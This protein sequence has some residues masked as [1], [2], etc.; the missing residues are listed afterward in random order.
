[1]IRDTKTV[2]VTPYTYDPAVDPGVDCSNDPGHTRQEFQEECDINNIMSR[3]LKTGILPDLIR[4]DARYGDFSDVPSYQEALER[5]AFAQTQFNALPAKLRAECAN[6]PAL[7]L[8]RASKDAEWLIGHGLAL[9]RQ[10]S[11][12]SAPVQGASAGTEPAQQPTA[13]KTE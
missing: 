10:Q 3:Y 8:E 1:M 2:F 9:P 7:F 5:V 12:A 4:E 6:D 13:A 11:S